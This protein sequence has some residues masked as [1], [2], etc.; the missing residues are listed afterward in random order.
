MADKPANNVNLHSLNWRTANLRRPNLNTDELTLSATILDEF[1]EFV[2]LTKMNGVLKKKNLREETNNYGRES[3]QP[4]HV[5]DILG[6]FGLPLC[7]L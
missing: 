1:A 4:N 7:E 3:I 6:H 5:R 2:L